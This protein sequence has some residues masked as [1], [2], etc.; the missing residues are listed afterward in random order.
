MVQIFI[1]GVVTPEEWDILTNALKQTLVLHN[2]KEQSTE[3]DVT[4]PEGV[5]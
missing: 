4:K 3:T 5:I 2:D 1:D